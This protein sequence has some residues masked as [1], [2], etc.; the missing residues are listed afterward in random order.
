MKAK[1]LLLECKIR[2]EVKTDY[3]LAKKLEIDRARISEYML[4]KK[5]PNEYAAFR[6]AA[7]LG[8]DPAEI[9]AEIQ[10]EKDEKN[11]EFW[12]DFLQLRG[13]LG[14]VAAAPLIFSATFAPE[15]AEASM[16]KLRDSHNV[17]YVKFRIDA[18]R[19]SNPTIGSKLSPC[20]SVV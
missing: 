12:R 8:R 2:L 9:I 18:E 3:A 11:R 17:Y 20:Y 15:P 4:G 5:V 6:I 13:L 19:R 1:E 7:A 14:L 10:A 16:T